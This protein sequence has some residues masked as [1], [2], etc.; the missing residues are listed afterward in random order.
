MKKMKLLASFKDLFVA[1]VSLT[2]EVV[3]DIRKHKAEKF[4]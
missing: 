3:S 1:W 2:Q 4:K